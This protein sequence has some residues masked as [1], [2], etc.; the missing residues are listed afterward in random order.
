MGN[1]AATVVEDRSTLHPFIFNSPF[2]IFNYK[3]PSL[4]VILGP[5]GVG[6]TDL[7]IGLAQQ[8]YTVKCALEQP[9]LRPDN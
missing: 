6:K 9:C 7:S 5:T 4:I 1:H 3:M 2:S 8:L